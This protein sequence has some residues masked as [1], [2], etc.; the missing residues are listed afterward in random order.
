MQLHELQIALNDTLLAQVF[1][2][3]I[4]KS[5]L[6]T[7]KLDLAIVDSSL[8]TTSQ[9]GKKNKAV[10]AINGGFFNTKEYYSV[11]YLEKE[12][13]AV[14]NTRSSPARRKAKDYFLNGVIL[15]DTLGRI[16][17]EPVKE[18]V[19]Y[20]TSKKERWVLVAG[21]LL[22]DQGKTKQLPSIPF[23]SKRHPRSC[24]CESEAAIYLIVV[25]GR[26]ENSVGINL[27]ELQNVLSGDFFECLNAVNLDGG[28]SSTLWLNT[29]KN[30]AV[31]NQPSDASGERK[32]HNA[33]VLLPKN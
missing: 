20:E 26:S 13:I 31:L 21:P 4:D 12:G 16:T 19:Y 27:N 29:N 3:K 11:T 22:I 2:F 17:F 18:D 6:D 14:A 10:A 5:L 15:M 8:Q 23:V 30:P 28:G 33:I 7:F 9:L 25:D 24:I 32:V 1:S